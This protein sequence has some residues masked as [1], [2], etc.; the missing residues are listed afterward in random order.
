LFFYKDVRVVAAFNI[1]VDLYRAEDLPRQMLPTKNPERSTRLMSALDA[2]NIREG[3]GTVRPAHVP[4][5]AKWQGRQRNISTRYT[6]RIDEVMR[7]RA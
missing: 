3:R 1:F 7:V 6:T 2:I 4:G 5:Q